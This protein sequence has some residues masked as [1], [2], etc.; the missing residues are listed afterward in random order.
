MREDVAVIASYGSMRNERFSRVQAV[1]AAVS[2][3]SAGVPTINGNLPTN[4]PPTGE[5]LWTA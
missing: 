3:S 5:L 4:T 2:P 1:S